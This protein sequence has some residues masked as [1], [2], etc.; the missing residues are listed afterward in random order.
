MAAKRAP[1]K[2]KPKRAKTS[3]SVRRVGRFEVENFCIDVETEWRHVGGGRWKPESK[4]TAQEREEAPNQLKFADDIF[5]E[6]MNEALGESVVSEWD[7]YADR[8]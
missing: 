4:K 7:D 2:K 8:S 5:I 3:F 6:I 1:K